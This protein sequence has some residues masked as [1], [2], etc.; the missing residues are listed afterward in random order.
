MQ[1]TPWPGWEGAT[2]GCE[3]GV[4]YSV[5][6]H[7]QNDSRALLD[8]AGGVQLRHLG[9]VN[10]CKTCGYIPFYSKLPSW[11]LVN[12][13]HI[14]RS[15]IHHPKMLSLVMGWL[16]RL[17]GLLGVQGMGVPWISGPLLLMLPLLYYS[18]GAEYCFSGSMEWKLYYTYISFIMNVN[19]IQW[20][21][22]VILIHSIG[23][24]LH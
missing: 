4:R 22:I 16:Y 7:H 12:L 6:G 17:T 13:Q 3:S 10:C 18:F 11:I 21:C 5:W 9:A 8:I 19:F 14:K 20:F 24:K 15:R 1:K 23:L 2:G